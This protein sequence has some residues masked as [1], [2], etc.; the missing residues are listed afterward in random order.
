M[1]PFLH[2]SPSSQA[3]AHS[4]ASISQTAPVKDSCPVGPSQT[5]KPRSLARL[6]LQQMRTQC[7]HASATISQGVEPLHQ[8]IKQVTLSHVFVSCADALNLR[9]A[10]GK[11]SIGADRMSD[12][13]VRVR[14]TLG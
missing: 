9:L 2:P 4:C 11:Q 13:L 1:R 6:R 5:R 3:S 12:F 8:F 10:K 14:R 7:S